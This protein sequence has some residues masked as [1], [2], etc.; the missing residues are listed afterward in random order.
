MCGMGLDG[1]M[2]M[3]RFIRETVE[4]INKTHPRLK[5]LDRNKVW[6]YYRKI[7]PNYNE[8]TPHQFAKTILELENE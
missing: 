8:I 5:F 3:L 6:S 7:K 2:T 1:R 4:L